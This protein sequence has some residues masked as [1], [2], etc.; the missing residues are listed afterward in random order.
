MYKIVVILNDITYITYICTHKYTRRY[1][2]NS[3]ISIRLHHENFNLKEKFI[4]KGFS[5][6]QKNRM[7]NKQTQ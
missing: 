4:R 6:K 1:I 7:S 3:Y 5:K 2:E